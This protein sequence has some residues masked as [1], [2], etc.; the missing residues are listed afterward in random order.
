[1]KK[2]TK[3]Q[4]LKNVVQEV[5][6]IKKYAT[7]SE[8]NKLDFDNLIPDSHS[9]CIYGQMTGDCRSS[10][11]SNLIYKSCKS[12]INDGGIITSKFKD[13]QSN[14]V[15]N[16]PGVKNLKSFKNN[17]LKKGYYNIHTI[18]YYSSL[19]TYLFHKGA[20]IKHI[21]DYLKGNTKKLIL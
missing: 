8:I 20:K 10:R 2:V 5:N 14:I 3:E 1:M 21:I 15:N 12:Y 11:A 9:R 19:E 17:R 4:F 7:K 6:N 13:I 16:I 18:E